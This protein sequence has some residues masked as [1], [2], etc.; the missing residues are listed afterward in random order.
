[1][2]IE[3]LLNRLDGV[4]NKGKGRYSARCPAH[5]DKSPSLSIT[6]CDDGRILVH[7]HAGCETHE[8][9]SSIGMT[10]SDL[11]PE[12]IRGQHSFKPIRRPFNTA[13]IVSGLAHEAAVVS[14]HAQ[15]VEEYL[16]LE[17]L[18]QATSRLMAGAEQL[19]RDYPEI[20]AL[21]RGNKATS[22]SDLTMDVNVRNT[23]PASLPEGVSA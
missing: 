10:F 9:L 14:L 2:S 6:E 17:R 23:T 4:H 7:C 21:R 20:A 3:N 8:V 13:Q 12:R 16:P 1:M 18:T 22:T 5:D 19:T 15:H 11:M